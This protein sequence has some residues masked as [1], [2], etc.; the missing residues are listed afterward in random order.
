MSQPYR[1][2]QPHQWTQATETPLSTPI[3]ESWQTDELYDMYSYIE[4]GDEDDI[5]DGYMHPDSP[6][7]DDKPMKQEIHIP[8]HTN[9]TLQVHPVAAPEPPTPTK[10]EAPRKR[11][12]PQ[13]PPGLTP[14]QKA[15]IANKR[16]NRWVVV[17]C[18]LVVLLVGLV[19]GVPIVLQ[20]MKS[21]G[22]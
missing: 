13:E 12:A 21:G 10:P 8:E 17:V 14:R 2:D 22:N 1:Y 16:R 11:Q 19:A 3:R 7:Y 18:V 6:P 9:P 20:K 4:N 5:V 15:A